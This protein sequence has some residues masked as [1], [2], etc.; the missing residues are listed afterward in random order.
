M[1]ADPRTDATLLAA[2][3]RD[4][5]AF[6]VFYLRHEGASWRGCCVALAALTFPPICA[7]RSSPRRSTRRTASATADRRPRPGC[8]A[9]LAT[10]WVRA[11]GAGA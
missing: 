5:S 8:S 10:S 2:T 11:S 9:S 6:A 1:E 3:G 7:P 4:P